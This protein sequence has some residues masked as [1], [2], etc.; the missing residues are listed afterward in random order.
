MTAPFY[1]SSNRMPVNQGREDSAHLFSFFTFLFCQDKIQKSEVAMSNHSNYFTII[2]IL[3]IYQLAACTGQI[4]APGNPLDGNADAGGNTLDGGL[5]DDYEASDDFSQDTDIDIS[6]WL[7]VEQPNL[8]DEIAAAQTL[9]LEELAAGPDSCW[10]GPQWWIEN[11]D[12][13]SH[14]TVMF[15]YPK[16]MGPHEVTIFDFA[17]GEEKHVQIN[18]VDDIEFMFHLVPIYR[19]G[20]MVYVQ[21]I[22]SNGRK[23]IWVYDPAANTFEFGGF[24]FG[25]QVYN[26]TPWTVREEDEKLYALGQMQGS[27][28]PAFY[29]IDPLS[30]QGE[31]LAAA[32]PDNPNLAWIYAE[33]V[34]DGDWIYAAVGNTPWRLFGI[35]LATNQTTIIAESTDIIGDHNTMNIAKLEYYPGCV[36]SFTNLSGYGSEE[37]SFWLRD[38]QLTPKTGDTPPWSEELLSEPRPTYMRTSHPTPD[39]LDARRSVISSDAKVRLWYMRTPDA[40]P[41]SNPIATGEWNFIEFSVTF[42]PIDICRLYT[43]SDGDLLGF[44][45]QYGRAVLF[46]AD[47]QTSQILG[48]TMEVYSGIIVDSK[49][50]L[51]GYPGFQVWEYDPSTPW[52]GGLF[53]ELPPSASSVDGGTGVDETTNPRLLD[54]LM[55]YCDVQNPYGGAALAAEDRIFIGGKMSRIGDGGGLGWWDIGDQQGGGINGPLLDYQVYWTC[56]ASDGRYVLASTKPVDAERGKLFIYD[57]QSE[58]FIHEIEQSFWSIP[59]YIVEAL[60]GLVMG[61]APASDDQ[62]GVLYGLDVAS[63]QILWT[64]PVSIRPATAMS[65][66]RRARYT[67]TK[68]PDGFIWATMNTVLTRIDPHN[69]FVEVLGRLP[70]SLRI[71]FSG[72]SVFVAG[73]HQLRRA[74]SLTIET[75]N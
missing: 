19:I 26:G 75:G 7:P 18:N 70:R 49:V 71:A 2:L 9:D 60:P 57:T 66:M 38:G 41:G 1:F 62:G 72:N 61:Y 74:T 22:T 11:P 64:K 44:G 34:A 63:G 23:A 39:G 42:Y 37:V 55:P 13:N 15:Y 14:D 56:S 27:M 48:Q 28:Q 54:R 4:S 29:R 58:Q 45:F 17:S 20:D 43:L 31:V 73:D 40:L 16:Y 24:P 69:A 59:G 67:F 65:E 53:S 52:T 33:S 8:E 10:T 3:L 5:E 36:A 47:G 12:G 21:P 68:G 50:Y 30:G 6:Q 51:G 46:S 35:N 25:D 32:G